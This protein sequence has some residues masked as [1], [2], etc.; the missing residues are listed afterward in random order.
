MLSGQ[1]VQPPKTSESRVFMVLLA[2][3]RRENLP[4]VIMCIVQMYMLISLLTVARINRL[5]FSRFEVTIEFV[6]DCCGPCAMRLY[7]ASYHCDKMII[8]IFNAET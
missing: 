4:V 7:Y 8:I 5:C 1:H 3:L 2:K 6:L